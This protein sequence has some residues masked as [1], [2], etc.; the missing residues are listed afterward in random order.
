M[1][2]FYQRASVL[3]LLLFFLIPSQT[4]VHAS[5]FMGIDIR[6]ECINTCTSRVYW[7]AYRDCSG[8]SSFSN[9][10]VFNS[11][12]PGCLTPTVVTPWQ[13]QMV[14]EVTPICPTVQTLCMNSSATFSGVE[15]YFTYQDVDFCN[16]PPGCDYNLEWSSCCRNAVITSGAANEGFAITNYHSLS[17]GCNNSP[18]YTNIPLFYACNGNTSSK[19]M[20]GVDPD[21]DSLI[22][23]LE[24]CLVNT[25]G[26]PAT[27][28]AG[29][30]P[31]SPL[32]PDW[33]VSLD[34]ASGLLTI[35]PNPGSTV[36]G[37]VCIT[38]S[39]YR[40]GVLIG[41]NTRD[42][43]VST[44]PCGLP[45]SP[46]VLGPITNLTPGATLTGGNVISICSGTPFCFD[47]EATDPDTAIG[48]SVTLLWDGS[49]AG[50]TF[51]ETGNPTN[52]DTLTGNSPNG[53]FCWN[54]PVPGFYAVSIGVRDNYCPI[55]TFS[56]QIIFINV[57]SGAFTASIQASAPSLDTCGTD[58]VVLS[59]PGAYT[60]YTWSN[61]S[62][63]PT[64]DVTTAGTYW[65][66]V[67]STG[68]SGVGT[69]SITIGTTAIPN[70]S[71]MVTLSNG[72]TPLANS[73]VY[74]ITH[75]PILNALT[76]IDS[77]MTDSLGYYAFCNTQG[78]DT[79]YLKAAPQLPAYPNHLPTYADTALYWNNAVAFLNANA[80]LTVDWSVVAGS[81]PGGPGFIGG[82]ISTG[83]NKTSGV[84]DPTPG[85]PVFLY[86]VTWNTYIG[87]TTTDANGYFS[88]P[89]LPYG[90]YEISVDVPGVD[91]VNVPMVTLGSQAPSLDSLDL[92]LHTTYLELFLPTSTLDPIQA[93]VD[94]YPNPSA[95]T[96]TIAIKLA[97]A[98]QMD[99]Q[100][101]DMMGR[102]MMT[103]A[104][105]YYESGER[106]FALSGLSAGTYFL[107]VRIGEA[108]QTFK[109]VHQ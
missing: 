71:G 87:T 40:N 53:T 106:K 26:T 75:D 3:V 55:T 49:I 39:E 9:N 36:V 57:Q 95:E 86:S 45:N 97:D 34:Y 29:Y 7:R 12:T 90:D 104:S 54:N 16:S 66:T 14:V 48:Q 13:T 44:L 108:V 76:A 24:T 33:N 65:V 18:V 101:F 4:E 23:T 62:I 8:I 92:R 72:S 15:E 109:V 41:Q 11:P 21:G 1:T 94:I 37:I 5:H 82:L 19:S 27:Y 88:F 81:N 67:T 30:S 102:E 46:P 64:I 77:T 69:D 107:Q 50:A 78:A 96:Q 31:T 35:V 58:T 6:M 60:S 63:A 99:I 105:G 91:E 74:L 80:P 93:E 10:I 61:G 100:L 56:D 59:V 47:L 25:T 38:T 22:Y 73:P 17:Q 103:V 70:I 84:G 51:V 2:Q 43:Q 20:G 32:G 98:Q 68:C 79:V 83:A 89:A 42:I 28:S 85:V 52:T